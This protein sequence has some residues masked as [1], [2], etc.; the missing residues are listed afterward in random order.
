MPNSI[1]ASVGDSGANV[2]ADVLEVQALLDA[3]GFDP[4]QPDG[5]CGPLTFAAIRRFQHTIMHDPDG[6]IE[7]GKIN[8]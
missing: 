3:Q 2:H 1:T 5:D 7:P 4:G 6:L 8:G